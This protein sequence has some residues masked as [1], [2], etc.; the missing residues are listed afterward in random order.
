MPKLNSSWLDSFEYDATSGTL[1]VTTKTGQPYAHEGVSRE[2]ADAFAA[3]KS[4]GRFYSER[5]GHRSP[6]DRRPAGKS[7]W[8]KLKRVLDG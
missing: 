5:F 2:D 7:D 6:A 1:T 8:G 3:A 4:P